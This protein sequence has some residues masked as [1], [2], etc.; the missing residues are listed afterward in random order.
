MSETRGEHKNPGEF[1]HSQ[2][3]IGG[4]GSSLKTARYIPPNKNDMFRAMADLESYMNN[5]D[6]QDVLVKAAL[7]HYQFETIHPFLD[8]NGR[9]GRLLIL[10]FLLEQRV[11]STPVLYISYFLKK[12]RIDYYDRLTEVRKNGNF[13]Q[14]VKFFLQ[15]I[16]ETAG[17][18]ISDIDELVALHSKSIEK[19]EK[20]G[21]VSKTALNL[22]SYLEKNPIIDIQKTAKDLKITF[23]TAAN[24]VNRLVS[25]G[26]LFQVESRQRNRLFAYRDYL[27]VLRRGC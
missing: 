24:S 10:L 21:K 13:E 20:L 2:N 6:E 8:G 25:L 26:I 18:A 12:N 1:R 17:E 3:W 27:E 14:W 22:F 5:P 15:A 9:V 23:K 4:L 19:I 7:I 11:L 16:Y